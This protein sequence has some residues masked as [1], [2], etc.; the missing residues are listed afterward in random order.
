MK[1]I[2]ILS[3]LSCFLLS[4][5]LLMSVIDFCSFDIGFYKKEYKANNTESWT[6]MSM[7]DNLRATVCLLDYLKDKRDDIR[8]TGTVN[9]VEREVF[10]ERETLHMVDVKALYQKVFLVRNIMAVIGFAIMAWMIFKEKMNLRAFLQAGFKEGVLATFFL[11]AFVAV[12][13]LADFNAFWTQFHLFFF[14]NDLWLLD[15]N[16][17]IMINLFPSSFFF[18]LVLR[19][20]LISLVILIAIALY[21]YQPWRKEKA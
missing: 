10:N 8:I 19:I 11:I 9:G 16:T 14:D 17:S 12:W 13:A 18:H 3:A 21:A 7:E 20:I 5:A 2:K 1:H 15:P 4:I 6:G